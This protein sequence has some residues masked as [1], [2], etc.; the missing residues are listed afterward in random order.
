MSATGSSFQLGLQASSPAQVSWAWPLVCLCSEWVGGTWRGRV[1]P[2]WCR[3][4]GEVP[5]EAQGWV[6]SPWTWAL[7]AGTVS[8]LGEGGSEELDL[9]R[10]GGPSVQAWLSAGPVGLQGSCG[11]AE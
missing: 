10:R 9:P 11:S 2:G 1:S 7:L 5:S 3:A 4:E 6:R 8:W